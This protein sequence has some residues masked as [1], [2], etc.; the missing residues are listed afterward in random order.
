MCTGKQGGLKCAPVYVIT[1]AAAVCIIYS[2]GLPS[3]SGVLSGVGPPWWYVY[4][5]VCSLVCPVVCALCHGFG[6]CLS[7][8]MRGFVR[9]TFTPAERLR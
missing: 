5:C 7:C 6:V 3:C 2:C 1:A 4:V 9:C 8:L